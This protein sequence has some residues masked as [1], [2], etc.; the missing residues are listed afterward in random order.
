MRSSPVI[1]KFTGVIILCMALAVYPGCESTSSTVDNRTTG[2]NLGDITAKES[3]EGNTAIASI[4]ANKIG[5]DAGE[6]IQKRMKSQAEAISKAGLDATVDQV[7]EGILVALDEENKNRFDEKN[8]RLTS[9]G[10]KDLDRLVEIFEE[11][12]K[13]HIIIE[14]HMDNRG[15]ADKNSRLSSYHAR[16][17]HDYLVNMGVSKDRL[18]TRWYGQKQ[19]KYDNNTKA[20]RAKN[21][22]IEMAIVAGDELKKAAREISN[23]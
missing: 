20:G 23:R 5:G 1:N 21:R 6:Y 13:T 18:A 2:I 3:G 14:G 22:R 10:K 16:A 7:M 19:P 15:D 11:Y 17:V 12:D 9:K 4:L 8:L